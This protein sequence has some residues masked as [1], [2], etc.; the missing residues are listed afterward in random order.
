M[1]YI[2]Q[3]YFAQSILTLQSWSGGSKAKVRALSNLP[4]WF[5]L[6]RLGVKLSKASAKIT[7][8]EFAQTTELLFGIRTPGEAEKHPTYCFNPFEKFG[9]SNYQP[10]KGQGEDVTWSRGTLWTREDRY[11]TRSIEEYRSRKYAFKKDYLKLVSADLADSRIPLIPLAAFFFRQVSDW[12]NE[13]FQSGFADQTEVRLAIIDALHLTD[14][15]LKHVFDESDTSVEA[16]LLATEEMSTTQVYETVTSIIPIDPSAVQS[17]SEL[18]ASDVEDEDESGGDANTSGG[19][20]HPDFSIPL[21]NDPGGIVGAKEAAEAALAALRAGK[22]VV[23]LGPPGTGKTELASHLCGAL[24]VPFVATTA[25]SDWSTFDTVGGYFPQTQGNELAFQPAIV[26]RSIIEKKWLI[27]DEMN[28]ADLDK[29]LGQLFTVLSGQPVTLPFTQDIEGKKTEISIGPEGRNAT[30]EVD[31]NWRLIGTMNTFDK[32]SLFQLSYALMRRFAFVEVGIPPEDK[33]SQLLMSRAEPWPE[34]A[35]A[36]EKVV[37]FFTAEHGLRSVNMPVGPAIALDVISTLKSLGRSDSD[38]VLTALEMYLFPQFE[39]RLEESSD[40]SKL[41]ATY[42]G[43][44]PAQM[45]RVNLR[46]STWAGQELA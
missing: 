40:L 2:S 13:P 21:D 1:A 38:A 11:S 36:S 35:L 3:E 34:G 24:G 27:I 16:E 7:N 23:L 45:Q 12:Q 10:Y 9:R 4:R 22:H 8:V 37:E 39:G 41:L 6:K 20:L 29:S 17:A 43:L 18:G 26:L 46:L 44:S 30:Y 19:S 25:T 33:F 32:A 28:R 31:N 15:E 5:V 42:F 14:D